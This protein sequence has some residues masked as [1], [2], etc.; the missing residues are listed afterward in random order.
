MTFYSPVVTDIAPP[1]GGLGR[2]VRESREKLSFKHLICV[3]DDTNIAHLR[4][5][6]PLDTSISLC[7]CDGG[8]NLLYSTYR[9]FSELKDT[10]VA[11][12]LGNGTSI[13]HH[14][15]VTYLA[16]HHLTADST[17]INGEK[18]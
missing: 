14:H 18:I 13:P 7:T 17:L 11:L 6:L 2:E 3:F 16:I 15:N 8:I 4:D 10:L 9:L 12:P 5:R 1:P